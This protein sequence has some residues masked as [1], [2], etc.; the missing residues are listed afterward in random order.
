MP[1]DHILNAQ[2]RERLLAEL[3]RHGAV[4]VAE[5]A[6]LFQ[7]SPVTVRRD[8]AALAREHRLV[9]VHGGAL[10]PPDPARSPA[11]ADRLTLGMIVP[12]LDFFWPQVITGAR[13][14]AA[15]LGAGLRLRGSGY[16]PEEDR[17]Q[18]ARL[19]ETG[20]LDGLLLAP[21]VHD[22]LS[23]IGAL[24][25]PCVLVERAAPALGP[26]ARPLESVR[27]DHDAGVEAALRH[28][29]GQG[30]RRVGLV[31]TP[32]SPNAALIEQGFTRGRAAAGLDGDALLVRDTLRTGGDRVDEVLRACAATG[33]TALLVHSDPDAIALA[34]RATETGLRVPG[35]LA[36]VSYDDEVARQGEPPLTAVR[37]AKGQIG[38]MAVE[39]LVSRLT[40]GDR[41][42]ANRL[43]LVPSLV[44][45]QSS[46]RPR[47]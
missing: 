10:L 7:V 47:H 20:R 17:R 5:L 46:L 44:V 8:I 11:P 40:E 32:I 9:R 18:I 12:D 1:D 42:P 14:A 45:R 29:A 2:R 43:Q 6:A 26:S 30:H 16:D 23:G 4:R 13:T 27:N 34:R 3:R 15:V 21:D 19:L 31:V 28:L 36:L 24:P 41:R 35:D 39:M 33:T 38:R 22:D 37:P 25:V